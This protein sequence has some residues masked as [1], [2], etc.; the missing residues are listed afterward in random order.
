MW[1]RASLGL[2]VGSAAVALCDE[3]GKPVCAKPTST[4]FCTACDAC[5]ADIS[6]DACDACV[7][8]RCGAPQRSESDI[9]N[10]SCVADSAGGG[11]TACGE[12]CAPWLDLQSDCDACVASF[13]ASGTFDFDCASNGTAESPLQCTL[14]CATSC[15]R[16]AVLPWGEPSPCLHKC[17]HDPDALFHAVLIPIIGRFLVDVVWNLVKKRLCAVAREPRYHELGRESCE[18][19]D[20]KSNRPSAFTYADI[21]GEGGKPATWAEARDANGQSSFGAFCHATVKTFLFHLVQPGLYFWVLSDVFST[22]D[23]IQQLFGQI[24]A[25]REAIYVL[26]VLL[27]V[28]C[29]PAFLL[30]DWGATIRQSEGSEGYKIVWFY[31]F[32]PEKFILSMLGIFD[33]CGECSFLVCFLFDL[34]AI[35]ALGVGL[36]LGNLPDALAVGYGLAALGSLGTAG[37]GGIPGICCACVCCIMP[38]FFI[39]WLWLPDWLDNDVDGSGSSF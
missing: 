22:L 8:S 2:I 11:C 4:A 35:C 15:V 19:D 20:L 12:C 39:S 32:S 7:A 34:A 28:L 13:C 17:A 27:G 26:A 3:L 14:E 16:F 24:V 18:T 21:Y 6:E 38:V 29:Y 25:V 30:I 31:M 5:C 36:G 23:P 9:R 33:L 37:I 1:L 10:H